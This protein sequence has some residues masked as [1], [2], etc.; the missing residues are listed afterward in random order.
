VDPAIE[1]QA[2]ERLAALRARRDPAQT[3]ALLARLDAAATGSDNLMPVFV[4]CVAANVTVGEICRRLRQVWGEY[5]P[6][7]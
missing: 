7:V 2:C 1:A 4:D 5:R 6:T 3:A